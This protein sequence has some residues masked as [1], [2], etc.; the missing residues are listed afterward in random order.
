[1]F[2]PTNARSIS[3]LGKRETSSARSNGRWIPWRYLF[4]FL[5]ASIA[6]IGFLPGQNSG[7][8]E[9]V[10]AEAVADE[11][12]YSNTLTSIEDIQVGDEILAWDEE[13]EK[14]MPRKVVHLF[15]NTSD[16][17]R[18]LTIKSLEGDSQE[19]G[20]TDGHPFW[21]V[22][23]GW[24]DAIDIQVGDRLRDSNRKLTFVTSTRREDHPEGIEIFNFEVE[25][26]HTYYA[27]AGLG[28]NPVLVHN[29]SRSIGN[30]A[31]RAFGFAAR[32]RLRAQGIKAGTKKL[33]SRMGGAGK[34]PLARHVVAA[35][36]KRAAKNCQSQIDRVVKHFDEFGEP[37]PGISQGRAGKK[38]R[39]SNAK[40]GEFLNKKRK[41]GRGRP[42]PEKP[43]GYY[44][45][46][47]VFPGGRVE[48]GNDRTRLVFGK[49]GEVYFTDNKTDYVRIR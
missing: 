38:S 25:G 11:P 40:P 30:A 41:G 43:K 10:T 45:E 8:S 32:S 26:S 24:V 42:L 46:T 19:I 29:N 27:A 36:L 13:R 15:R 22:G 4:A 21:V 5:C 9:F 31:K 44:T 20:T 37:P 3:S 1:M 16:H 49:E 35:R 18:F 14:Q 34:A 28:D 7:N 17:I 6:L 2:Q 39:S 23:E 47:D 33:S 48:G 12:I